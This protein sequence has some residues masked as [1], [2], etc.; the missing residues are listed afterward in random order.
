MPCKGIITPD[1]TPVDFPKLSPLSMSALP[2]QTELAERLDNPEVDGQLAFHGVGSGKSLSA[3]NAAHR[4]NLPFTAIVPASLR[5]NMH[6]EIAKSN[7]TLP[8]EVLSY[9]EAQKKLKDPAFLDRASKS[10]VAIDEGHLTAGEGSA[11]R[12]LLKFLPSK[13]KLILTG[14][15]IR[16]HPSEVSPIINSVKPGALPE[17]P[18]LFE[19]QYIDRDA[20]GVARPKNLRDFAGA[21][22]GTTHHYQ[23]NDPANFPTTSETTVDVPMSDRQQAAYNFVTGQYPALAYKLHHGLPPDVDQDGDFQAFLSGPRQVTNHPGGFHADATD[24]DATKIQ[25][26][27]DEIHRRF[28][29][30]KN[31]RGVGYSSFIHAGV[32]P[33]SRAL[34]ARG[35]PHGVFTGEQNDAERKVAVDDYNEGRKPVLLLSG[36]GAAGLDLKGTKHIA[37]LE[38]HWNEELMNQVKGR[39]VRYKSHSHLPPEERHVEI[40]R[41]HAVHQPKWWE[42]LL[43]FRSGAGLTADGYIHKQALEKKRLNEPF[44][45]VLRGED[46]D[47]VEAEYKTA[48]FYETEPSKTA[49]LCGGPRPAVMFDLDGTI[50]QTPGKLNRMQSYESRGPAELLPKRL[51][52]LRMLKLKGYALVAV[53]NRSCWSSNITLADVYHGLQEV[54]FLTEGLFE[55]IVFCPLPNDAVQKPAPTMLNWAVRQYNLDPENICY[56]G[57]SD[58]DMHAAEAAGIPFHTAESFFADFNRI[59]SIPEATQSSDMPK[60]IH[61]WKQDGDDFVGHLPVAEEKQ[62]R[63]LVADI[64][65]N[66]REAG[67]EAPRMMSDAETVIVR[68]KSATVAA[69]IDQHYLNA[70]PGA[71]LRWWIEHANGV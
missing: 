24:E 42:K 6:K 69:W 21:V 50:V 1:D 20:Q 16:N 48:E 34:T 14:T 54:E 51:D 28:K 17:D 36:A 12:D 55:D 37:I 3:L 19:H 45:R 39:G 44:L 65:S 30:D 27:A 61:N 41:F 22:Y 26:A 8:H 2:H 32:N 7:F 25:T 68:T 59:A 49:C 66:A 53:T 62:A 11:R 43:G 71:S 47:K 67:E 70:Y 13:K 33:L 5:N 29:T 60:P 10:L 31:Y 4:A 15:P 64:N 23:S 58:D 57:N 40:Q 18:R 46:P 35:I 38:P 9:Q 63:A 52:F 56:V